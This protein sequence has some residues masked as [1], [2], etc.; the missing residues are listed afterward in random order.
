MVRK[1]SVLVVFVYGLLL[2]AAGLLGYF[3]GHSVPSLF[4]GLIFGSIILVC[5]SNMH[6]HN[7]LALYTALTTTVIATVLFAWRYSIGH[8]LSS[9][10]LALLSGAVLIYLLTTLAKRRL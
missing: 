9:A 6:Q 3:K 4:S 7:R 1:S 8:R 10:I 2:I 5:A